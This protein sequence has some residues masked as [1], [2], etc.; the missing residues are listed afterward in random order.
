[1]FSRKINVDGVG[2][3]GNFGCD[4]VCWSVAEEGLVAV[5]APIA[6]GL[7]HHLAPAVLAHARRVED[8]LVV[9]D[10]R[11]VPIKKVEVVLVCVV[12][13]LQSVVNLANQIQIA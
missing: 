12:L 2:K 1:M 13:L 7:L 10:P 6:L 9:L 4:H 8:P 11:H 3:I 5:F